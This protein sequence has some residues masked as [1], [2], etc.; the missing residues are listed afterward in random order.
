MIKI[1]RESWLSH[2]RGFES[3]N[4]YHFN[5]G[6]IVKNGAPLL[7]L[8][9]VPFYCCQALCRYH[10]KKEAQRHAGLLTLNLASP[11]LTFDVIT[12]PVIITQ[13]CF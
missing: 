9:L 13:N 8:W 3:S 6:G 5:E 12:V 1:A 10:Q 2:K 7:G 4:L 11:S